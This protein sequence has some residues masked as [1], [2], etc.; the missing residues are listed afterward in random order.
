MATVP[1]PLAIAIE[2]HKAGR[3]QAAEEI[4]RRILAAQPNQPDALNLL[5]VLAA[6]SGRPETAI[7]YFSQAVSVRGNV[8]VLHNN[9]GN[10]YR[11]CRRNAEAAACYRRAVEF[12]P[13]FAEAH[14][15]LGL[16]LRQEG[17]LEEAVTSYRRAIE[18]VAWRCRSALQPG[19]CVEGPGKRCGGVSLLPP[20]GGI[21]AGIRPRHGALGRALEKIGDL[22]GAETSYHSA[23]RHDPRNAYA[24]LGLA[25]VLGGGLPQEHIEAQRRLLAETG[26]TDAEAGIVHFALAQ[27]LDARGEYAEAA[28]HLVRANA[29]ELSESRRRGDAFDPECRGSICFTDDLRLHGGILRSGPRLRLGERSARVRR[30]AAALRYHARRADIGLPLAGLCRGR[31]ATGGQQPC[32]W[33]AG[34]PAAGRTETCSR[35]LRGLTKRRPGFSRRSIWS[36]SARSL[37]RRA[38]LRPYGLLTRC[39]TTTCTW[40][41]WHVSFRGPSSFIAAANFRDVA[42]SCWMTHFKSIRWTNDPRHIAAQFR[43][44]RR[45]MEHWRNVLPHAALGSGLRRDGGRSGRRRAAAGR[46]VLPGMGAGLLGVSPRPARCPHGQRRPGPPAGLCDV[47]GQMEELRQ[48][49]GGTI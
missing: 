34:H 42:V 19:P 15:N 14:N 39:R 22:K 33:A 21:E 7:E 20:R 36:N 43:R 8:A 47:G 32:A 30:R 17:K 11:E 26:L 25:R 13:E 35:G 12:K 49:A 10:A 5:G 16:A 48:T 6:Q 28:E 1:E 44:Y 45:I 38:P 29:L 3:L 37:P 18:L 40:A 31:A 2:H 23:L 24:H 4:Y 41:S 46:L 9:L 27:V